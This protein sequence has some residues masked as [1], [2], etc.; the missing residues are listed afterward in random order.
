VY[1][2]TSLGNNGARGEPVS[3]KDDV[4]QPLTVVSAIANIISIANIKPF[5]KI[6]YFGG[7]S[8]AGAG[9]AGTASP[10]VVR[11]V[12]R[13]PSLVLTRLSV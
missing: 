10:L 11:F 5:T 3:I 9:A 8:P 1:T 6:L 7:V 12:N 2:L 4:A 13:Q